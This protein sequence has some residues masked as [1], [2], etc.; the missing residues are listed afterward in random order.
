LDQ[1]VGCDAFQL[2]PAIEKSQLHQKGRLHDIRFQLLHQPSFDFTNG[3]FFD[4]LLL[5]L[6]VI[7][8]QLDI[9][10]MMVMASV[11]FVV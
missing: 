8:V 1:S 7:L 4:L 2:V 5:L 10:L 9:F 6:L 3:F 11:G